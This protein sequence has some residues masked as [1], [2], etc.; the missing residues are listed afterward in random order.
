ML[1]VRMFSIVLLKKF[2]GMWI[3]GLLCDLPHHAESLLEAFS[4][5]LG[6]HEWTDVASSAVVK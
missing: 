4:N 3:S 5:D 1:P 2:S 6:K